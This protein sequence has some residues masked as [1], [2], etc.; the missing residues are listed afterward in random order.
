MLEQEQV[1][2]DD[3]EDKVTKMMDRLL[4]L[5]HVKLSLL[6][7]ARPVGLEVTYMYALMIVDPIRNQ[8]KTLAGIEGELN[9]IQ[10]TLTQLLLGRI[11][12]AVR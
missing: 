12:T 5:S 2:L 4:Q 7:V 10:E 8:T 3:H 6:I 11:Q 9:S 1:V